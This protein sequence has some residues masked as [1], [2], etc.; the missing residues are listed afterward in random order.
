M[1]A[2]SKD[3]VFTYVIAYEKTNKSKQFRYYQIQARTMTRTSRICESRI[4]MSFSQLVPGGP[5]LKVSISIHGNYS[6]V[7]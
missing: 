4:C 5:F 7:F 3:M 1:S 6:V 2:N